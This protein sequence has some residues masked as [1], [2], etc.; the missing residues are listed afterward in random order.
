MVRVKI[1]GITNLE[2]ALFSVESGADAV[3]FV[4]YPKS[5]R[6]VSPE[7]AREIS[8]NLPPFVFRVG[9]FVN[10]SFESVLDIAFH[11]GLNAVQLHGDESVEFC[12][13]L[14]EKIMVIKAVGISEEQDVKRAL[15]YRKFPV[16]LDTKVSGYGGSGKVF[17]W[18]VVLPYR[19]QFRYLVL[20]GGLNPR[21]VERAIEMVKPFAVDVSSGVEISPGKKDHNLVR[22]FIKKAKGL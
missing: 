13:K 7:K 9:V 21:N 6:Y 22:E 10:E 2:D 14:N 20:S 4:F 12:E 5:K 11:A 16:L 17:N 1:C 15:E 8:L 18:S 19:D 3:G